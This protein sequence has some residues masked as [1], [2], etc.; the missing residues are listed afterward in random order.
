MLDLRA[1]GFK[2]AFNTTSEGHVGWRKGDVLE[3]KDM[4]FSMVQF[5]G[6]VDSDSRPKGTARTGNDKDLK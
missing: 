3:Y 2:V 4:R 5:R 1:S 6:S